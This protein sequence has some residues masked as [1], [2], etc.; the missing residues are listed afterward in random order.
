MLVG[1]LSG[2]PGGEVHPLK[3]VPAP[4][5]RKLCRVCGK[6]IWRFPS[7][8]IP[9]ICSEACAR[10]AIRL[11]RASRGKATATIVSMR[12]PSLVKANVVA[13]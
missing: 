1:Q 9:R 5:F 4:R 6:E 13:T 10:Q 7:G 3:G 8:G 12:R 11:E 2:D